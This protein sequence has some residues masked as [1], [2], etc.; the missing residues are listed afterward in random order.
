[1]DLLYVILLFIEYS[2]ILVHEDN[3]NVQCAEPVLTKS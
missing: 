3:K 2:I 1:M